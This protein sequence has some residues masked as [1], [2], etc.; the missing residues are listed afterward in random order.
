MSDVLNFNCPRCGFY[1][2]W[3]FDY[4][5]R[6]NLRIRATRPPP[7]S[8]LKEVMAFAFNNTILDAQNR[9]KYPNF[10]N[11]THNFNRNH[12]LNN[13]ETKQKNNNEKG[14]VCKSCNRTNFKMEYDFC[15]YCGTHF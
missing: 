3:E 6:C 8:D 5:R 9:R 12:K 15:S 11:E 7:G 2:P 4:C 14:L 10:N 13:F 1:N